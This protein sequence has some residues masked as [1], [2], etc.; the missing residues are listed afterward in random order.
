MEAMR[1]G[2]RWSGRKQPKQ[3]APEGG[4]GRKPRR[5]QAAHTKVTMYKS[6]WDGRGDWGHKGQQHQDREGGGPL[7]VDGGMR[8]KNRWEGIWD[9]LTEGKI[10]A[11]TDGM[12]QIFVE[13]NGDKWRGSM[14]EFCEGMETLKW[15]KGI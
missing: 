1:K 14:R 8:K 10:E 11:N 4:W 6:A 15:G 3:T 13:G 12:R 7:S 2:W 5:K 9:E